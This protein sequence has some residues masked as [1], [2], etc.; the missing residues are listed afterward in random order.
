MCLKLRRFQIKPLTNNIT[1][2]KKTHLTKTEM[3]TIQAQS[4][5]KYFQIA[6]VCI[7]GFGWIVFKLRQ[8]RNVWNEVNCWGSAL[9]V[10]I[11]FKDLIS[12]AHSNY[13]ISWTIH[14][15]EIRSHSLRYD[16]QYGV[17]FSRSHTIALI[18]NTKTPKQRNNH[19]SSAVLL[20]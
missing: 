6:Y 1:L 16:T 20:D 15:M 5:C 18:K 10:T 19:S 13:L 12:Q 2:F 7:K 8:F 11:L 9:S 3:Q 14:S 4:R 17:V